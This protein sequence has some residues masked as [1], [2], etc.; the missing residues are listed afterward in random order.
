MMS[1]AKIYIK[2]LCDLTADPLSTVYKKAPSSST[3]GGFF[4]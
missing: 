3:L 2:N 1:Q 4:I